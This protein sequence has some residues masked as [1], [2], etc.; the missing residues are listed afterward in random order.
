M[1]GNEEKE[2][3]AQGRYRYKRNSKGQEEMWTNVKDVETMGL[4]SM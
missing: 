3:G 4:Q 2:E 1:K